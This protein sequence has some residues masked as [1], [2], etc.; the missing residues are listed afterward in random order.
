MASNFASAYDLAQIVKNSLDSIIWQ[1]GNKEE[2]I[3]KE[4][5]AHKIKHTNSLRKEL[6]GIHGAKTGFTDLAGGNL[7]L[8]VERPVGKPKLIVELSLA[9]TPER[10]FSTADNQLG[11]SAKRP[12]RPAKLQAIID[13]SNTNNCRQIYHSR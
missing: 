6:T 13:V 11:S 10:T 2:V 12:P 1:V 5:I 3:G 8:I 4:G 9:V 7:I